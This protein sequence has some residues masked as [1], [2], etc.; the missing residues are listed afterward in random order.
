MES[1]SSSFLFFSLLC[2]LT[3]SVPLD[4]T[5]VSARNTLDRQTSS[6]QCKISKLACNEKNF[7]VQDVKTEKVQSQSRKSQVGPNITGPYYCM[8]TSL[9]NAT[10][11]DTHCLQFMCR[12]LCFN[13]HVE[14]L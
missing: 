5:R 14:L 9:T 2:T 11:E 1:T 6:K 4:E 10:I 12:L 8:K 3:A 7:S 13:T